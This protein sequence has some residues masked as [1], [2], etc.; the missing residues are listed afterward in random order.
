MALV[1][2]EN[3]WRWDT[4]VESYFVKYYAQ[5]QTVQKVRRVHECLASIDFP[6]HISLVKNLDPQTI[7]QPW[8]DAKSANYDDTLHRQKAVI[9]LQ[10]LHETRKHINWQQ[11]PQ[12]SQMDLKMKWV[13]RYE[14]FVQHEE[15]LRQWI[16][17]YYDKIV[18]MASDALQSIQALQL[19]PEPLTLLHGDVVH[20][21]VLMKENH[22]VLIDFDLATVGEASDEM[23]LWVLRTLPNVDYK[24][25]TLLHAHPYLKIIQP[26]LKYLLFPNEC[27]REALYMLRLNE[28]QR[29]HFLTFLLPFIKD[30]VDKR[31]ALEQDI[32]LLK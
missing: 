11:Q 14:R 21:N 8:M 17:R 25:E 4:N 3:C 10:A 18:E 30:A 13:Q 20:H 32:N 1:I 31:P 22:A 24:L 2:K 6:H 28:A 12:I 15:E 5:V 9:A 7:I 19:V 27:M 29:Q 16:G 23:I 26:K